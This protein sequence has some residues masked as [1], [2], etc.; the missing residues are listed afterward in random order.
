MTDAGGI[1]IVIL[2]LI[3]ISLGRLPRK[4]SRRLTNQEAAVLAWAKRVELTRTEVVYRTGRCAP[5]V[6]VR[7]GWCEHCGTS[8]T[9]SVCGVDHG[10]PYPH[11]SSDCDYW[12]GEPCDCVTARMCGFEPAVPLIDTKEEYTA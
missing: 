10:A 3:A 7:A 5:S 11:H 12:V 4:P 9:C 2:I 6:L 8:G 1:A